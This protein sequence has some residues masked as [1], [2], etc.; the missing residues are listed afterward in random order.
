MT[1]SFGDRNDGLA[2]VTPNNSTA[3]GVL[4]R[5]IDGGRTWQRT[6]FCGPTSDPTRTVYC[7]VPTSFGIHG[8]VLAIAQN[9][10]KSRT[11]QAFVYTTAD[12]GADWGR[13]RLPPLDSPEMPAF[14]APNAKDLFVYSVNGVLHTSTDGGRTWS[15]IRQ[16]AFRDLS[17]MQFIS[18]DYGWVSGGGHFD[19][20]TDAGR[21]W[22]PIGTH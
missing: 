13:H 17:Q 18:A 3:A 14:S 4:Y 16:P 10:A 12:S 8:V 15:S 6:H 22:K 9:L 2:L 20:T 5:T 7:G 19:Y 21:T 1:V 11:D